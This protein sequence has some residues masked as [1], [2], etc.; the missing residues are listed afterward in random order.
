MNSDEL[1]ETLMGSMGKE[2]RELIRAVEQWRFADELWSIQVDAAAVVE[3]VA[4]VDGG[5]RARVLRRREEARGESER[6]P[7]PYL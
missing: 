1:V 2:R 4:K 6:D 3:A 7:W 5:G